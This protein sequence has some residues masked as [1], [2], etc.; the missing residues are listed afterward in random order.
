LEIMGGRLPSPVAG[1]KIRGVSQGTTRARFV[2]RE[3]ELAALLDALA[4]AERGESTTVLVGGD[5]GVGKSRLVA[6]LVERARSDGALALVGRCIDVGDGELPYAPIAAALRSMAAQLDAAALD[7]ALGPGRAEL[8]RLVPHLGDA[9]P[10][11]AGAFGRARLYELLLG[12]LGRLGARA[13]VVLVLEDLHWADGSTRDLLRFLVRSAGAERLAI[14]GTYRTDELP[15]ALRPFL[16]ELGRDPH[17]SRVTLAPFT[18]AELGEHVAAIQGAAPEPAA[19]DRLHERSEG[20]AFFAEELLAASGAGDLPASLREAMLAHL[21][22]LPEPSRR[23]VRVVAAAGRRVHHRL[24]TAVAAQTD[25]DLEAALRPAVSAGVLVPDEHGYEFRH[26]LL[27]EAAY[28]EVMPGE[29]A[30]LHSALAQRLEADPALAGADTTLAAELAYH[31]QAAG[32]RERALA[33]SVRAGE[34]AERMYAHPEALRHLQRAL[35]LWREGDGVDRTDLTEAA[36]RAADAAGEHALA[37]ALARRAVELV[38]DPPRAGALH[39]ELARYLWNAGH[40]EDARAVAARAVDLLPDAATPERARALETHARVLLLTGH[41]HEGRAPLEEAIAIARD[42]NLQT[43]EAAA[44]ATLVIAGHGRAEEAVATGWA[45]LQ[46]ARDAGTP[47]TLM[48]AYTNAAEALDQAGSVGE[49]IDLSQEGMAV[50]RRLGAVR[51]HGTLLAGDAALRLVKLG[52]LDEAATLIDEALGTA[53]SG[54]AAALLRQAAATLAARRGDAP[55]VAAAVADGHVEAPEDA[56]LAAAAAES[57]LWQGEA[58]RAAAIVAEALARLEAG[59]FV[60]FSAPLYSLGA[61]AHTELALRALALRDEGEAVRARDAVVGLGVRLDVRRAE[62]AGSPGAPLRDDIAPPEPAAHRAQ[63][64]AELGRIA[65]RPDAEAW[66]QARRRWEALG[67]RFHVALCAWREAEALLATGGDRGRAA[68]LL[69]TARREAEV[70]GAMPLLAEIEALGRRG[71][72]V[73]TTT[74]ATA[75]QLGLSPR[76]LEVLGLLADGRTNREI[77]T[78][79]FISEKTVSVHVSRVLSKLDATNRTQAGAIARRV[80]LA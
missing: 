34:E 23:L 17:V 62:A 59:E 44:L 79:L 66:A 41:V 75:A 20:N 50:A 9:P 54:K 63:V 45:A 32:E 48:R 12:A 77:A 28:A 65:D 58:Q 13:P 53:P 16:V 31:W 22:R 56:R 29:R 2:A 52:R 70:L 10:E 21:D 69:A 15:G 3:A 39:T 14:V 71:R 40:E 67:F 36:A 1:V 24:L 49:A 80:G 6:E 61:W 68:E 38:D 51:T 57:A 30:R 11:L 5:A 18:R 76:E 55:G 26:A 8:A 7:E 35:E 64:A 4:R 25:A 27:R 72:L 33:A 74:G 37:I 19:L 73:P 43:V 46:A 47:E 60:L 78:E 42:L